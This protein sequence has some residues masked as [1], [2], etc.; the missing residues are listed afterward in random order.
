MNAERTHV[1]EGPVFVW[2]ELTHQHYGVP[3][4]GCFAWHHNDV[5]MCDH[6][7]DDEEHRFTCEDAQIEMSRVRAAR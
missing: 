3:V 6:E 4:P 5:S 1:L 7:H 2:R